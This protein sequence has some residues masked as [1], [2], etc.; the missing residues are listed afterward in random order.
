MTTNNEIC[1]F[2]KIKDENLSPTSWEQVFNWI[3][4]DPSIKA[5]TNNFRSAI[6]ANQWDL[7]K[8]EHK[9]A[10]QNLKVSLL[11]GFLPGGVF[12]TTKK[13]DLESYSGVVHVDFDNISNEDTNSLLEFVSKEKSA[14]LCFRSPGGRGI[15]IFHR[16]RPAE[17]IL[18]VQP[19]TIQEF[20]N[21]A[22]EEVSN[23]Y[24][25]NGLMFNGFDKSV[26]NINRACYLCHDPDAVIR[27]DAQPITIT[28]NTKKEE[29]ENEE[30]SELE[31]WY[32]AQA[33]K[34]MAFDSTEVSGRI[35]ELIE[36]LKV[37]KLTITNEYDKWIRVIF[38]LKGTFDNAT[39]EKYAREFSQLDSSF[40]EDEF[41]KKFN[42]KV[43]AKKKVSIG[44][45]MHYAK[46]LG[47][48]PQKKLT[49]KGYFK[50][51]IRL[52]VK[53]EWKI[54]YNAMFCTLEK[55][56]EDKWRP[57]VDSDM[58][59]LKAGVF[60]HEYARSALMETLNVIAPKFNPSNHLKDKIQ[61]WDG[62]DHIKE[63][64]HTLDC[65][66]NK[67][68]KIFITRWIMGLLAGITR[69]D[70]Y[71]E[72]VL[73]LHGIQGAGKTRWVRRLFEEALISF[74]LEP[75]HY[76]K[77]KQIDPGNKDDLLLLCNSFVVFFDEMHSIVNNR[78]D[79]EAFKN[80]TSAT[81]QT[82]R[83][84]YGRISEDFRRYAS[85]I[86]TVNEEQFLVDSTGNRRFWVVSVGTVNQ[87]HSVNIPQ[88]FAQAWHLLNSGERYYLNAEEI[89]E[90]NELYLTRY[91]VVKAEEEMIRNYVVESDGRY[92]TTTEVIKELNELYNRDVIKCGAAN[93]GKLLKK[94]F[95]HVYEVTWRFRVM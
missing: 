38:A 81:T 9:R 13:D 51:I 12:L 93:F 80:M 83:K 45:I 21:C 7:S 48:K 3:K 20:H 49:Q 78:A 17:P 55:N 77:Q 24:R 57:L 71:N 41:L 91:E 23:L 43:K 65:G 25:R 58:D 47:Y 36:W 29:N 6:A 75:E 44:T 1:Y 92:M 14:M 94:H 90:L 26:S 82:I 61:N 73:I 86:G 15:K 8:A 22:F 88:V 30:N 89:K 67:W 18:K 53:Y 11:P 63:L 39:A 50:D 60:Q 74:E 19:E 76:F 35:E 52:L 64:V 95:G 5:V 37:N 31:D 56:S 33:Q 69:T 4:V 40:D 54:R 70:S 68:A 42:Q 72:N 32:M 84:P 66:T 62:K 16:I 59:E 46:E 85:I 79:I 10:Y 2:K 28:F 34:Y 27:L 87:N